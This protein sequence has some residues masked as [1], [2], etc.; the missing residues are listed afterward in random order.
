MARS[1]S[2]R[3]GSTPPT[4]RKGRGGATA[5]SA[6]AGGSRFRRRRSGATGEGRAAQ[7]A[8]AYRLTKE[9]DPR[10][11]LI[12]LGTFVAAAVVAYALLY[13]VPPRWVVADVILALLFAVLV[14]LIV[15]TRRAT[16]AQYRQIEGK[17][18]AALA[19]LSVLKRGWHTDQAVAFTRNQDVVHRVV[20]PPGIVL[21]GEG[22]ATRVRQLLGQERRKYARVTADTPLHEV[23]VGHGEGEVPLPKLSR[24]LTKM[25]REV[26]PA[27]ITDIRA[28]LRAIDATRSAMPIP[29]GPVPTSMKG[30]RGNLRGR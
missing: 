15:F 22:N 4:P 20:G 14:T 25:K 19:A 7:L 30:M 5:A 17:P 28:R 1:G 6:I 13:L 3:L 23:V 11:G 21:V 29:K 26:K 8:Q 16:S 9:V 24:T 27:Q 12:L 10:I 18:G 2:T